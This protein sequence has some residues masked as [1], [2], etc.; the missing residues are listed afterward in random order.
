MR[1]GWAGAV[2]RTSTPCAGEVTHSPASVH[3]VTV[4]STLPPP[5]RGMARSAAPAPGSTDALVAP[6]L[7]VAEGKVRPPASPS[8]QVTWGPAWLP[9]MPV[10]V[11]PVTVGACGGPTGVTWVAGEDGESPPALWAVTV[12]L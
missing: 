3:A 1:L 6:A 8:A 10:T 2:A 7:S 11:A 12:T 4:T 9:V 5:G